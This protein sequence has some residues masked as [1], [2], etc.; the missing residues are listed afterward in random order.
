MAEVWLHQKWVQGWGTGLTKG[1]VGQESHLGREGE[2]KEEEEEEE[3][4]GWDLIRGFH[5]RE[6]RGRIFCVSQ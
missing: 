5:I 6:S 3:D 1:S 4:L 2:G